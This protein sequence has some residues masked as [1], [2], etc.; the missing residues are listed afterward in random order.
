MTLK[1]VNNN[2]TKEV[3][4]VRIDDGYI[5]II[6]IEDGSN[7]KVSDMELLFPNFK[8][9]VDNALD[10]ESLLAELQA[11]NPNFVWAHVSGKL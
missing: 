6:A 3:H 8:T 2:L 1:I 5:D 10:T 11:S 9:I 7:V 4:S